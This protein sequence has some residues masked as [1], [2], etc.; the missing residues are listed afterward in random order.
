[1]YYAI[2]CMLRMTSKV[3]FLKLLFR[4][5]LT[6]YMYICIS[7]SSS[8]V[9][10]RVHQVHCLEFSVSY[11][12]NPKKALTRNSSVYRTQ[13]SLINSITPNSLNFEAAGQVYLKGPNFPQRCF[14]WT[15]DHLLYLWSLIGHFKFRNLN[16]PVPV[17]TLII[18]RANSSSSVAIY[19]LSI[20]P[21]TRLFSNEL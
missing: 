11:I 9:E 14:G 2:Y 17:S 19:H 7:T 18:W 4:S 6:L 5:Y 13:N 20:P 15:Q 1:M 12:W 16:T 3:L 21:P 8:Q 10:H